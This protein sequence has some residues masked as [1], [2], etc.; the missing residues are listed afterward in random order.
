MCVVSPCINSIFI[1]QRKNFVHQHNSAAGIQLAHAGRKGSTN[2]PWIHGGGPISIEHG[3]W[4][5]IGPTDEPWSAADLVPAAMSIK[6]ISRVVN[7]F[8]EATIRAEK[9]GFDVLEIHGAHGYLITEFLSPL[10]N[11]R[12][13]EYG[14]DFQR[15]TK[16]CREIISAVRSVWPSHKP[17]FL[18]LSCSEWVDGGW[19][20]KD[21]VK[22]AGIAKD[23]GVDV[24]DCSSGGNSSLQKIR[25]APGFQVPFSQEIKKEYG[26]SLKTMA[27]GML[28]DPHQC[29][30]ILQKGQAD[31][32]ALAREFLREPHWPLKAADALGINVQWAFQYER[33]HRTYTPGHRGN[34]QSKL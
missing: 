29:E 27:V 20:V 26:T 10:S 19:D 28:T 33:G 14:G 5:P 30:E 25:A 12:T 24:I 18:R 34:T 17:L 32:V 9:A 31:L 7:C 4:V 11:K 13:D 2:A 16:F 21:T 1:T 6:D 15:R 3:G 22:L 23:M 8:K